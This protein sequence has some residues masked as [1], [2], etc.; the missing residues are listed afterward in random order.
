ML[1]TPVAAS[2]PI[3]F[4]VTVRSDDG[5][6]WQVFSR[7]A[8]F[9][10][11]P[12]QRLDISGA[13]AYATFQLQVFEEG[14]GR[15]GVVPDSRTVRAVNYAAGEET[16]TA[17]ASYLLGG[18]GGLEV[19]PHQVGWAFHFSG[20]VAGQRIFFKGSSRDR[21]LVVP[22]LGTLTDINPSEEGIVFTPIHAPA[23]KLYVY[24]D[25]PGGLVFYAERVFEV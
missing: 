20:T 19:L 8:F 14:S 6:V 17:S 2:N 1:A 13:R 11:R 16:T 25:G 9:V 4:P 23:G 21:P 5:R 3:G 24:A 15:E 10:A 12:F 22:L 7:D 18:I